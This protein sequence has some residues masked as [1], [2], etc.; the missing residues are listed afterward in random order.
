MVNGEERRSIKKQKPKKKNKFLFKEDKQLIQII[1]LRTL[2][3]KLSHRINW[4]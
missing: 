4:I 2:K 3:V 1:I